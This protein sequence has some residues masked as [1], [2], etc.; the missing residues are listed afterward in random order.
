MTWCHIK[1]KICNNWHMKTY[2]NLSSFVTVGWVGA[3]GRGILL[4]MW[5]CGSSHP[6][7]Q[8]SSPQY[9]KPKVGA[10]APRDDLQSP[11]GWLAVHRDQL[12]TQ[13]SVTSMGELYLCIINKILPCLWIISSR[14]IYKCTDF[15]SIANISEVLIE[16]TFSPSPS[17]MC[18]FVGSCTVK[19]AIYHCYQRIM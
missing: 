9:P 16:R 18:L 2:Q 14:Y 6:F 3:E 1:A 13:S 19:E 17:Y 5:V 15:V 10:S 12:R 4:E 8:P 11:A 7:E